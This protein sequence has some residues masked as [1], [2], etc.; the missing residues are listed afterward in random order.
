MSF[1]DSAIAVTIRYVVPSGDGMSIVIHKSS[2]AMAH[3]VGDTLQG[4]FNPRGLLF[5]FS[6]HVVLALFFSQ[7][8]AHFQK[9]RLNVG[10]WRIGLILTFGV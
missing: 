2:R 5:E 6:F 4:S 7:Q 10:P 9:T 8:L 1:S 3:P